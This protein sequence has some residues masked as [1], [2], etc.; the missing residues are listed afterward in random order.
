MARANASIL[1]AA[2]GFRACFI[3]ALP[4]ATPAASFPYSAKFLSLPDGKITPAQQAEATAHPESGW[5][6]QQSWQAG[7]IRVRSRRKPAARTRVPPGDLHPWA[8]PGR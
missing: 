6:R 4:Y 8:S 1:T 5:L 7:Q 2:N 3:A